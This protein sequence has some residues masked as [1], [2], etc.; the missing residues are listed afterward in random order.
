MKILFFLPFYLI[1]LISQAQSSP[2]VS[3]HQTSKQAWCFKQDQNLFYS[4]G[5]CAVNFIAKV[6]PTQKGKFYQASQLFPNQEKNWAI[7]STEKMKSWGFNT[8]GGW[9]SESI[10]QQPFHHTR[11]LTLDV[12]Q[13][14]TAN[15]LL[16]IFEPD[17]PQ[18]IKLALEKEVFPHLNNTWLIGWF[19]GNELPWQGDW[20]WKSTEHRSLLDLFLQLPI[21]TAGRKK[22][23]QFLKDYYQQDFQKFTTAWITSAS[24]WH[25]LELSGY[26]IGKGALAQQTKT[27]WM[28][29]VAQHFYS[30]ATTIL[31]NIDPNHLILG[32]RFA[33]AAPR[34]VMLACAQ[35]C[36]VV[37]VN[38][39]DRDADCDFQWWDRLH[40][41][42]QKPILI[43][44]FS[45]SAKDNRS[46]NKNTH[47]VNVQVDTQEERGKRYQKWVSEMMKLPYLVGMHWFLWSDQPE[48]GRWD[49]EDCN[50]GLVDYQHQPYTPLTEAITHTHNNFL[51]PDE[52]TAW[53][54][55]EPKQALKIKWDE[56]PL[57]TLQPSTPP[58]I[59]INL[60]LITQAKINKGT[61]TQL[62]LHPD[63]PGLLIQYNISKDRGF[64]VSWTLPST[65][66]HHQKTTLTFQAPPGTKLSLNLSN[67]NLKT[68][69]TYGPFHATG[70]NQTIQLQL[71]E[72]SYSPEWIHGDPI[73]TLDQ[74]TQ[75]GIEINQESL[76]NLRLLEWQFH[77]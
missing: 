27:A 28:G 58:P 53:Q 42:V 76:G 7:D 13:P 46:G 54:Y 60:Q 68:K 66:K 19:L 62:S 30:T 5:V 52:R 35:Y 59:P 72:A 1:S 56:S 3:V 55:P 75:A 25:D 49:G 34:P 36:D 37:S 77:N 64:N 47:G 32:S 12:Q 18:K 43:T 44:E 71:N 65:L 33:G 2:F 20:G 70:S 8:A 61:S 23:V 4:M 57:I 24:S 45:W 69:L 48:N 6:P 31:K 26:P 11:C 15:P 14:K 21:N 10:Y 50:Y 40:Q 38:H 16:I 51:P 22:A 67:P 29:I 9:S 73:I 63:Q 39:Y 41:L 17:Y 74:I